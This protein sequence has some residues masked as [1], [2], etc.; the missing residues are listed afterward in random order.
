MLRLELPGH[1][2]VV[3]VCDV[4]LLPLT[5]TLAALEGLAPVV[6]GLIELAPIVP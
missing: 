3:L 5:H 4:E 2:V 6:L 1:T